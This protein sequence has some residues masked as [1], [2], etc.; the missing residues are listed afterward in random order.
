MR[1]FHSSPISIFVQGNFGQDIPVQKKR[2]IGRAFFQP[3]QGSEASR[4]LLT[5]MASMNA[6]DPG[7]AENIGILTSIVESFVPL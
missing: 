6:D 3:N 1:G 5:M 7:L 2:V 4:I